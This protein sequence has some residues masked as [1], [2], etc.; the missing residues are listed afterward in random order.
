MKMSEEYPPAYV[1]KIKALDTIIFLAGLAVLAAPIIFRF[2]PGD[3]D[4]T[5][6]ATFGAM[7]TTCA[8][9]RI[10][11][12]YGSAWLEI[13]LCALGLLTFLLPKFMHMSHDNMYNTFHMLAGGIIILLSLVSAVFT[14][15]HLRTL[16]QDR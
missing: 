7:I 5:V 4:T 10:L 11:V 8:V 16:P 13:V 9:F 6:H 3:L 12:A 2:F 1:L 14:F 15:A